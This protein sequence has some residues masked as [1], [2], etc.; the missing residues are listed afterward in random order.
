MGLGV[1]TG[2][3][4]ASFG[5]RL[6]FLPSIIYSQMVGVKQKMLG[7]DMDEIQANLKRYSSQGNKEAAKQERGK[8]KSL[9]RKHGI[10]PFLSLTNLLQIPIHVT[11]ASLIN[12]SAYNFENNP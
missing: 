4:I 8:M 1:G 9:R 3:L 2:L 5:A 11:W 7:P 12:V 10:Y 6:F